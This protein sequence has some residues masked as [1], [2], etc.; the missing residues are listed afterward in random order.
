MRSGDIRPWAGDIASVRLVEDIS[1]TPD[2]D[3]VSEEG[4]SNI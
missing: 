2:V 3:C 4:G 1:S